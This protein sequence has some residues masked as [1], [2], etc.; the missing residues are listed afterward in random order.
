[1]RPRSH[2]ARRAHRHILLEIGHPSGFGR[3]LAARDDGLTLVELLVV[4]IVVGILAAIALPAFLK[5]T[6]KGGYTI[7][8]A[9]RSG[10]AF[11]IVRD[12]ATGVLS[13]TCNAPGQGSC[14]ATGTW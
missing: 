14:S 13:H 5:Q 2:L 1:M 12:P 6:S 9:S 4:C 7:V 10:A 11:T 8:Y 3:A